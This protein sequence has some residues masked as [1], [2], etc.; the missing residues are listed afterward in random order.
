MV[1][2]AGSIKVDVY[3]SGN[4]NELDKLWA[5]RDVHVVQQGATPEDKGVNIKGDTL[6]L[7]RKVEGS[8]LVVSGADMAW[9][10]LDKILI[11]G[12]TVNIDQTLN[13]V[14]VNGGGAMRI[15]SDAALEEIR[16]SR[17]PTALPP[18][19]EEIRRSKVMGRRKKNRD[20]CISTGVVPCSSTAKMQSSSKMSRCPRMSSVSG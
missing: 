20:Q 6:E 4:K 13:T 8:L 12:P 10:E 18:W 1:L 9:L 15:N 5:E 19:W 14:R 16:R 2:H 11:V 7:T 3:C 17:V